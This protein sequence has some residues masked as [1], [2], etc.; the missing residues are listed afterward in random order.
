[1]TLEGMVLTDHFLQRIQ[2]RNIPVQVV[3]DCLRTGK[4]INNSR[5]IVIYNRFIN[6]YMSIKDG[7]GLTV[8]LS[9]KL[10]RRIQLDS[11]RYGTSKNKMVK[12][13]FESLGY[14]I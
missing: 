4:K 14:K 1:M 9:N 11:K 6:C 10:D 12:I 13:Y 5:N 3:K 7:A 2:D 8:K